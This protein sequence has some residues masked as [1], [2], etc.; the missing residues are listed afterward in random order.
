MD[1]EIIMLSEVKDTYHMISL[2]CGI[3]KNNTGEFIYKTKITHRQESKL[4]RYQ[5]GRRGIN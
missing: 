5:K 1:P 2:I 4:N 3:L